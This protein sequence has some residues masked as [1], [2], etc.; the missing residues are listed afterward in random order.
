M[1][2]TDLL[3]LIACLPALAAV[4][5]GL[6]QCERQMND[7]IRLERTRTGSPKNGP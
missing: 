2:V 6:A 5:F 4:L 1:S 7:T 3:I